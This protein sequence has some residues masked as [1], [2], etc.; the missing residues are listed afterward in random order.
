MKDRYRLF[1]RR[2]SIY[3]AFDNT[4]KTFESLKTK[5]KAQAERLLLAMNEAGKQP[6]MNLSLARVYLKHSDPLVSE[7]TWQNV[8]DEIIK[9]QTGPTQYRWQTAAK[10]KAFDLIR[11]RL[12]IET[13]AEHF[14]DVLEQ[15]SVSTNSYLRRMHRFALDMNWLPWVVLPTKRW[16]VLKFKQKRAITWEEHQRILASEKNPE[17]RSYYEMLWHLGGSQTDM[18]TLRAEDIN[19]TDQTISYERIKTGS[20]SVIHFGQTV[21]DLLRFRPQK[22]F[23]FPMI[24]LWKE[25]SRGKAF[26]RRCRLAGVSGVSLHSYRYAWAERAKSA[27][28]PERFAQQALGHNSIA[29]HRAYAKRAL[30]KIPSLEDY[31]R[32]VES[33]EAVSV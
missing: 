21:A 14:L 20:I 23:L 5:D 15:G 19:W 33:K 18:A 16:P 26:I 24:A 9:I 7:R 6:A 32:Q 11:S 22:G 31:E 25:A 13:Q 12:L 2:K 10:D 27:G 29:V 1:L 3:Y 30:V 17:W 28:Y 4:T 8:V